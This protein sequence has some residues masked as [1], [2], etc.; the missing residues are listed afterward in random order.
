MEPGY[1]RSAANNGRTFWVPFSWVYIALFDYIG[2][3]ED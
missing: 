3:L 2:K 1:A